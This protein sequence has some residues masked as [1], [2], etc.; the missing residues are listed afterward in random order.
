M[1]IFG[2]LNPN[3]R[4]FPKAERHERMIP[5]RDGDSPVTDYSVSSGIG[6]VWGKGSK[7]KVVRSWG[8]PK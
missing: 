3:D 6:I 8:D 5:D 7:W 1:T 2:N 4:C